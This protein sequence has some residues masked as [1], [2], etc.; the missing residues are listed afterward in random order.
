MEMN[1]YQHQSQKLLPC[2]IRQK[3]D[4]RVNIAANN[5]NLIPIKIINKFLPLENC[6]KKNLQ[7]QETEKKSRVVIIGVSHTRGCAA[8]LQ[9]YLD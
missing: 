1:W 5:N 6:N 9:Y 3:K 8:N 2:G 7:I 4:Y